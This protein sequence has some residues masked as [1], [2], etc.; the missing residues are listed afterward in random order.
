MRAKRIQQ[1]IVG[2]IPAAGKAARLSPLPCSKE[3]YP[4]GFD[5]SSEKKIIRPK[6]VSQYLI[7]S[8][9]LVHISEVYIIIRK[10]KWDIP[11]YLGSG[12]WMDMDFAYLIMDLPFGVP[13]TLDQAY[14]F[15][16]NDI[17]VFG[18]PDIIFRPKNAFNQLLD[19]GYSSH[20]DVVLGLF[21]APQPHKMQ[22]MVDFDSSGQVCGFQIN[23]SQTSLHYTWII[24]V[25][26]PKFTR[27]LH[28][29]VSSKAKIFRKDGA[30]KKDSMDEEIFMTQAFEVA[31]QKGLKIDAVPFNEGSFLD[32][33]SPE[34]LER[35]AQG[36]PELADF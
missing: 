27:F 36:F 16:K 32:I 14:H 4:V 23:P 28:E 29:Y 18:F 5:N 10:G 13:F 9:R 33:G 21:R 30:L 17:V 26:H 20:A 35:T 15:V 31:L 34:N 6:A 24:A 7:E 11:Q 22:H 19:K 1:K 2:L 8:M 25:W 3:I 12:K